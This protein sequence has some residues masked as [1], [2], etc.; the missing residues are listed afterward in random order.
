MM[1]KKMQERHKPQSANNCKIGHVIGYI[2]TTSLIIA[3]IVYMVA[4]S[5]FYSK[6]ATDVD[7]KNWRQ[8]FFFAFL[9]DFFVLELIKVLL[10]VVVLTFIK[11]VAVC[12]K[13][14]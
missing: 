5:V 11:K 7:E 4:F 1:Y 14:E 6:E 9:Q 12:C 13:K 3:F 2:L 10:I 8:V